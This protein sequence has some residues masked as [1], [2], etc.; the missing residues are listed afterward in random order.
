MKNI[1]LKDW[2]SI[3]DRLSAELGIHESIS[4]DIV[5]FLQ[6]QPEFASTA[7]TYSDSEYKDMKNTER[8]LFKVDNQPR[9]F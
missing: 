5:E 7:K 3:T 4:R 9:N 1:S 6:K 2:S 8:M